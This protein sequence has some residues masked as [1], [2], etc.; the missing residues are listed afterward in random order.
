M[1]RTA[2]ASRSRRLRKNRAPIPTAFSPFS[3]YWRQLEK[4]FKHPRLRQ[5]FGRYATYCGASPYQAA[6]T[7]VVVP[8]V[9]REGSWLVEGGMHRVEL[10]LRA[11]HPRAVR[12]HGALDHR[13]QQL[14][15]G[16]VFER[17]QAA[18]QGVD[19]DVAR[20]VEGQVGSHLVAERV[21]DDVDDDGVPC[22]TD[23]ADEC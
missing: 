12:H 23:V 19:Q 9:E 11:R 14:A 1:R 2:A 8:H 18:A 17:L 6:A 3:T 22:G 13:A 10:E 7:M 15:G 16:R 20:R 5:L 4:H 21:V